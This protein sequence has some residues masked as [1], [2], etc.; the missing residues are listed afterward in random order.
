MPAVT[1]RLTGE[2]RPGRGDGG[3][4]AGSGFGRR[5]RED[6]QLVEA[7]SVRAASRRHSNPDVTRNLTINP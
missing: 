1:I 6:T 5:R 3:R 4:G 7:V 2:L